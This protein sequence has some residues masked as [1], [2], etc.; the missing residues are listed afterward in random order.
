L[1]LG[2]VAKS[3][4]MFRGPLIQAMLRQGHCISAAASNHDPV[5][6][7]RLSEWGVDFRAIKLHRTGMNPFGEIGSLAA[8]VEL[9]RDVMPDVFFGYT[10]KPATLGMIAAYLC[11]V[12]E[13]YAFITG[14]GYPY[15]DGRELNRRIARIVT[16]GLF[17]LS[18][19]LADKV[20]FQNGDDRELFLK[21]G[22]VRER[23]R[24]ACV[25]GS[26]VDLEHYRQAPIAAG[27]PVFLMITRLLKDKGVYEFVE[28][29]RLVRARIPN[30]R[31]VLV[32]PMDPNPN[33]VSE[34][35]I[36]SWKAEGAI[37]Y[38][39]EVDDVRPYIATSTA[40]IFPST[41]REGIP[42]SVLEALAMGRPIVTTDV[43]GC[44]ETVSDGLNGILIPPR[45]PVALAKAVMRF[46]DE[47]GL[48]ARMGQESHRLAVEKFAAELVSSHLLKIMNLYRGAEK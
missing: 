42:R 16:T 20:I 31:F 17:R 25:N 29:A 45:Q 14:L 32:G 4:L 7:A 41:Y 5:V 10:V 11:K 23:G 13:R 21:L 8:L 27:P 47:P 30:A 24:T 38:V 2:G 37:E 12:P 19:R 3:L 18:L 39:G 9:V 43:P 44:R 46:I 34:A 40:Y 15:S 6:A 36:A 48:V 28:A 1:I 35:E 33:A 22:V 26:G